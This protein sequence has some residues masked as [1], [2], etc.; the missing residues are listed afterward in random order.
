MALPH[1]TAAAMAVLLLDAAGLLA[2]GVW[3]DYLFPLLWVSP[4][5]IV[6]GLQTVMQE[7]HFLSQVAD[8]DWSGAVAAALAA[9]VCG[10]LWEMWNYFSLAKWEYSI[11]FVQRFQIFEMPLL[12]YAG[13]LPFGLECLVI[14]DM[15]EQLS[16][17][18]R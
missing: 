13:Y 15:L 6:I 10:G 2:I 5:L 12:G 8:G 14:G 4:L 17:R 3:P 16:C 1:P 18:A 9:L 11:P 7:R